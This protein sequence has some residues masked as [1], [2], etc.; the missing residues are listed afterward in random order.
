M[1]LRSQHAEQSLS[2]K[3]KLKRKDLRFFWV[4]GTPKVQKAFVFAQK[5][6]LF[7]KLVQTNVVITRFVEPYS[8]IFYIPNFSG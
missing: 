7:F 1:K 5:A 3:V 2:L 6:V 8:S 4:K